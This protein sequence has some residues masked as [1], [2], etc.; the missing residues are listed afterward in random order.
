MPS[1]GYRTSY[2]YDVLGNL[3]KVVQ[4]AQARYF[5]YDSLSRLIR[6]RNPEQDS[7]AGLALPANMLQ[8][9]S[10][11]NSWSQAVEYDE[12]GTLTKRTDARASSLPM[13]T[14]R[15]AG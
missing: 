14:T 13:A 7:L 10:D 6:A 3:R 15:W 1:A 8:S 12:K 9:P 2:A 11:N 5:A 4:G